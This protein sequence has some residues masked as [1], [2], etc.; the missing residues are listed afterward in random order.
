MP[1]SLTYVEDERV[2]FIVEA[3]FSPTSMT[4]L[5]RAFGI[6]RK[7]GYKWLDRYEAQGPAGLLDRSRAPLHSPH[8]LDESF[9]NRIIALRECHPTWGPRKLLAW[10][11]ARN[12]ERALP[13]A[14]TVGALLRRRGLIRPR[15]VR[16]RVPARTEPF[17]EC[18]GPNDIWCVDF[19]GWFRVGDGTRCYPF[20]LT[21]AFSRYLLRCHGLGRTRAEDVQPLFTSAFREYGMPSSIRSDNGPPFA[22]RAPGGLTSLSIWWVRLGIRPERIEP[23][24]PEQNG[25]HERMHLTLEQDVAVSPRRTMRAQQRAFDD[26]RRIFN[27]ERPHEAL[28]QRPPSSVYS[29][30]PRAFPSRLPDIEYPA[31]V[32]RRSVRPDG[33]IKWRGT[34]TYVGEALA[35]HIVAIEEVEPATSEVRFGTVLLGTIKDDLPHL[36]LIRPRTWSPR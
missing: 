15:R 12:P 3:L 18:T 13:A 26:F 16:R 17:A 8:Q 6:S 34:M 7:T 28:G 21:D 30:A 29:P 11:Q 22:S 5:C 35:G 14:S 36:G 33:R 32:E 4:E 19:K 23:G 9:A 2:Q 20:T 24:K 25:R 10:L 27:D 31:T 1:W